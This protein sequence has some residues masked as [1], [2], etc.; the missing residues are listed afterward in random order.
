MTKPSLSLKTTL[1]QFGRYCPSMRRPEVLYLPLQLQPGLE[2]VV[3]HQ[4]YLKILTHRHLVLGQNP[5]QKKSWRHKNPLYSS[6]K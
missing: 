2:L 3:H 6:H 4:L 5:I 1:T